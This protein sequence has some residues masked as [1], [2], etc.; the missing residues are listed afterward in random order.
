MFIFFQL[1]VF[2]CVCIAHD[3]SL[4]LDKLLVYDVN[5]VF[6]GYFPTFLKPGS[7]MLNPKP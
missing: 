5:C 2:G 1:C 7:T 3:L 4:E 6:L